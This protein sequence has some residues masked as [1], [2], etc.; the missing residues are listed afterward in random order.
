MTVQGVDMWWRYIPWPSY[1]LKAMIRKK[2]KPED[3]GP[4]EA[5]R[6]SIFHRLSLLCVFLTWSGF[7]IAAYLFMQP[8][9]DPKSLNLQRG[10][11][12]LDTGTQVT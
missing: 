3:L 1:L 7:G 11:Y 8:R 4:D 5:H 12:V 2:V 9:K 10:S 6:K